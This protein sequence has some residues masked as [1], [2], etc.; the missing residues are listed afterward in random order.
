MKSASSFGLAALALVACS[1]DDTAQNAE[2]GADGGDVPAA[3]GSTGADA[4]GP[5]DADDF[6]LTRPALP[7]CED[8]DV[9][10]LPGAFASMTGAS[11]F[12]I[13]T[14]LSKSKPRSLL[15]TTDPAAGST[16][17]ARLVSRTLDAGKK[18]RSLVFIRAKARAASSDDLPLRLTSM[19]FRTAAG[20]YRYSFATNGKGEWF[21]EE[22]HVPASGGASLSKRFPASS[23][24]P[25]DEWMPVRINIDGPTA[26]ASTFSVLVGADTVVGPVPMVPVGAELAPTFSLGLDGAA[27]AEAWA[28]RFDDVTFHFE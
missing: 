15:L 20:S 28:V 6:C 7:F 14:T 3:D 16:I 2:P 27:P 9:A 24:L 17:D 25:D 18:L 21:G 19:E 12:G 26:D 11:S 1:S 22:L 23:G 8:F 10:P 13:D 4:A 5:V